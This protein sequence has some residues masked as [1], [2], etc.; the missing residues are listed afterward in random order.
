LD[1]ARLSLRIPEKSELAH[2]P[3]NSALG[4]SYYRRAQ[5]V[6]HGLELLIAPLDRA[7]PPDD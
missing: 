2:D 7:T 6:K 5:E 1:P 3:K 4:A